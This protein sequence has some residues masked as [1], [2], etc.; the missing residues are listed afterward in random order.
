MMNENTES[1]QNIDIQHK[2]VM[3]LNIIA[4]ILLDIDL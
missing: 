3:T 1:L 4:K 2:Q